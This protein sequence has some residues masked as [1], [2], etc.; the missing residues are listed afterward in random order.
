MRVIILPLIVLLASG[1]AQQIAEGRVR[2][3]LVD[4]GLSQRHA[5]CMAERMVDRLTIDQ[6]KKL[7]RVKARPG[8]AEDPVS[9][10][11]YVARVRRVGD[12]EVIGVTASSAALCATGLADEAR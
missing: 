1:C 8:E 10:S 11:D 3:A 4:A 7:E 6:L 2:T 12:T 9:L 5:G